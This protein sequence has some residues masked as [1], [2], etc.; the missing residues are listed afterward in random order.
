MEMQEELLEDE[1]ERAFLASKSLS[2]KHTLRSEMAQEIISRQPGFL[3]RWSLLI[4]LTLLLLMFGGTWFVHYPDIITARAVLTSENNPKE[5]LVRQDGV[6]AKL[7]VKNDQ[8]VKQNAIIGWLENTANQQNVIELS[9]QIDSSLLLLNSNKYEKIAGVINSNYN[10]LGEVQQGYEQFLVAEDTFNNYA[11]SGGSLKNEHT[12]HRIDRERVI[13]QQQLQGLK[14]QV[15]EWLKKYVI[16]AAIAGKAS[17]NTTIREGQYLRGGALLGYIVP[18]NAQYFAEAIL[19]QNNFGKIDTGL[20]VQLRFDAY[21]YEEWGFVDGTISYISN[22]P[23]E[24]GFLTTIKLDGAVTNN[25]KHLAYKSGLRAQAIIITKDMR[26]LQ[27]FYYGFVK[28]T[29]VD[30]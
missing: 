2:E 29:S 5:I 28:S 6:L 8:V 9:A 22:V 1:E 3:E 24:N 14:N 16:R 30:K 19:P 11:L 4:F 25:K 10:D 21:P 27:R 26:L 20:H 13:F 23:T 17:L 12:V 15:N 18:E 7:L